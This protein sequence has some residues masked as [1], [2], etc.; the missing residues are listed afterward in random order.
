M[1]DLEDTSYFDDDSLRNSF[2][3]YYGEIPSSD[4]G[5]WYVAEG[6]YK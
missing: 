6:G 5:D 4:K 3:L 2:L 1:E